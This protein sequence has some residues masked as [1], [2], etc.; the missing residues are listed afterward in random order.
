MNPL[1]KYFNKLTYDQK[2]ALRVVKN[3]FWKINW[4][5]TI[6]FN[7]KI[8]PLSNA[9]KIPVLI[10]Y[11]VK[12]KNVGKINFTGD[13]YTGM[14]SLGVIRIE[15]YEV[16]HTPLLFN[17]RGTFNIAGR[18][19]MH[20][21]SIMSTT[22]R[23]VLTV[24]HN[25]GFGANTKV[26]SWHAITIGNNVRISWNCQIFDTDFHFLYN[27]EKDKYY[28]R[29][30]EVIIGNNVFIGNGSTIGKGT[31]IPNGSVVSCISKISGDFTKVGENLLITGNPA[32]VVKKGVNISSGWYP[33]QE[34]EIAKLINE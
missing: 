28:Q 5:K 12:I 9:I 10:A 7:F 19:K 16:N 29:I 33:E 18:F 3:Y 8:L 11:N 22:P 1:K 23:A 27:I 15:H 6:W 30:K 21:G 26:I 17:N 32:Q 13:L 25:V 31:I 14:V 34:K 4:L 24:G 2:E 20:P